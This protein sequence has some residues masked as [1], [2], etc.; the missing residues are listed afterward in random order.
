MFKRIWKKKEYSKLLDIDYSTKRMLE[1]TDDNIKECSELFSN[2][3]GK[4]NQESDIRP[5]QQV[6]MGVSYYKNN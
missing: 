1:L 5:G 4:Y 2:S 6:K 3:Y